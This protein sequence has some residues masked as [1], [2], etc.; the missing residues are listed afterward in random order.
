[1]IMVEL[2]LFFSILLVG[3]LFD[4]VSWNIGIQVGSGNGY[5]IP[6]GYSESDYASY[7]AMK[8]LGSE[9]ISNFNRMKE[10]KHQLEENANNEDILSHL[11]S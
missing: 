8:E 6:H 7:K 10:I 9:V 5:K 4:T 3:S 2:F 11:L 1:M